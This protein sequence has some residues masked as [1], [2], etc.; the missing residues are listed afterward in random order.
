MASVDA[1]IPPVGFKGKDVPHVPY[2]ALRVIQSILRALDRGVFECSDQ[3]R[4]SLEQQERELRYVR[5]LS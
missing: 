5:H 1:K 4:R 2:D 3:T